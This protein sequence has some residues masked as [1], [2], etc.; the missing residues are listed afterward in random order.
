MQEM[1]TKVDGLAVKYDFVLD[2]VTKNES[3]LREFED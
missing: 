3:K 1:E 2:G